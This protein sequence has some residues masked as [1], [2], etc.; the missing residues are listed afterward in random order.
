[1]K[2]LTIF[3]LILSSFIYISAQGPAPQN[4]P[5]AAVDSATKTQVIDTILK[6]LNDEYVF[7]ETAKK[8]EA[9]IRAR[10]KN[11][12]YDQPTARAF[13]DKL[14]ADLQS[15]SHDKHLRV[16][17]SH[18]AIPVRQNQEEPTDA[19]KAEETRYVKFMNSGF[20][21]VE[22]MRGNIG[23]I[24]FNGFVDPEKGAETVQ[25]AMNFVANTDALIFDL[26]GN[27]GGDPAIN[28]FRVIVNYDF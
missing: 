10:Q 26:R 13:A 8:M 25:S 15:V 28:D 27:G 16:R 2:S 12:E 3:L 14:T 20:E 9:D 4:Q 23:Y 22:R 21:Q 7:P 17:Y 6:S 5:D 1:M 18:R 24:R 19:E 11:N